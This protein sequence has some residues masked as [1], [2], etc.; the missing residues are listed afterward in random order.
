LSSSYFLYTLYFMMKQEKTVYKKRMGRPPGQIYT[1]TV[2]VRL[3]KETVALI[4]EWGRQ[5]HPASK[6]RSDAVRRLLMIG[7]ASQ[8]IDAE[9]AAQP[10]RKKAA[11]TAP[12]RSR[13]TYAKEAR[14]GTG[15][16]FAVKG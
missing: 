7:I 2:L 6:T 5:Q 3:T 15:A 14:T 13:K 11:R 4:T 1:E 10:A 9:K 12:K 16:R 8:K